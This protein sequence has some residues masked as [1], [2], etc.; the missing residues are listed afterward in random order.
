MPTRQ[1]SRRLRWALG[2]IGVA[3]VVLVVFTAYQALT[4]KRA[5]D[6]AAADLEPMAAELAEGEVAAASA[7]LEDIQES[8]EEARTNTRG[9][10]WWV[11]ARL[12]YLGD[13]VGA[14]QTVADVTDVV[15]R[16]VLPGV[17]S[18]AETLSP[19]NL[20]PRKGRIP[21][22]P[23]ERAASDV[24]AVD[25]ELSRQAARIS[26]I[27]TS[28]L[29]PPLVRPI[30]ELTEQLEEA[31]SLTGRASY[32]V[33][34]LPPMLGGDG[35]RTHL[36]LFQNN[37]EIRAT[38]GIPGSVAVLRANRGK[39]SLGEQGTAGSFGSYAEP[40]FEL[41]DEELRVYGAKLGR[42]G[43]D[44]NFTPDFPRT[45]EI[46][47]TMWRIQRGVNVDGVLSVDPV[48]LSYLLEA[49]GPVEVPG[50][51]RLTARNAVEIL[52]DEVY[53]TIPTN[54][55][56]N[57][58]FAAA[59]SAVFDAVSAGRGDPTE[60]LRALSKAASEGRIYVWSDKDREQRLIEETA[61]SGQVPREEGASPFV[62]VFMNDG[63][64]AKMQYYLDHRVDVRP[65]RCN[66]AGRQTLEVTVEMSSNA[67]EN[68]AELPPYVIGPRSDGSSYF[69]VDPGDMRINVHL[70]APVGGWI[71]GSTVGGEEAPLSE[72][73]HLGHPVG[74][75]SITLS[76]GDTQQL[77]YTVV[78]GLDQPGDVNLRVTPGV[79]GDGR[80]TVEPSA[81]GAS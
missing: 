25:E 66:P 11:G 23:I 24:V 69:G 10:G 30:D 5:L 61:L 68:V 15:A 38:G 81:C 50:G 12:P 49:T 13:D 21:V 22:G 6:A 74:S 46:A 67:P 20:S 34:L 58:Y 2:L 45:G 43:A 27:D 39:L 47:Q 76:P 16:D 72:A 57:A 70:Y 28:G 73:E 63:T 75:R 60:M 29:L 42:F 14:V 80:G 8:A 31:T 64:A 52:L 32:A 56:Q 59:A 54:D 55:A 77:T 26:A 17:V 9:P 53:R 48:A 78:T 79:R 35:P 62:G 19:A 65:V 18:A 3:V 1:T 36:L 37:A 41:T 33:R 4:A 44:I 51:P 71:D 7:R 40:P